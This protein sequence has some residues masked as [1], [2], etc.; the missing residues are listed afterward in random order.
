MTDR[1]DM[2]A[3]HNR[4]RIDPKDQE[5]TY[6]RDAQ[7][8]KEKSSQ[9]STWVYIGGPEIDAFAHSLENKDGAKVWDQG[10]AS[11]REE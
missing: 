8:F 6:D 11:G 3:D 9:L 4:H 10:S 7:A 1:K 5:A 2:T